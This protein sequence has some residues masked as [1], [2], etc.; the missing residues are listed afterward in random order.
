MA[1]KDRKK[2]PRPQKPQSPE[3]EPSEPTPAAAPP[4]GP[5]LQMAFF[6]E[7][8]LREADG[9]HSFIRQVDRL[10]TTA[11]GLAA[12]AKMPAA[13]QTLFLAITI[14]SGGA[15]GSHEIKVLRERPS[16]MRDTAPVLAM[17]IFFE[18]EERGVGLFGPITMTFEEEGLYWFDLYVDDKLLTRMPIRVIYQRTTAQVG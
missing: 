5:Y 14:K 11:S 6:C 12:P 13:T 16:G 17:T 9:V 4:A 15:R 8:V 7:K 2:P 18:G 3:R 1:E 10:T